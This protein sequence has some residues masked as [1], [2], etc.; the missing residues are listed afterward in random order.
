MFRFTG[1]VNVGYLK[2]YAYLEDHPMTCKWLITMVS[3]SPKQGC[4]HSKWAKW[5]ING[6]DPNYILTGMILQVD[7]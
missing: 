5:F 2:I 4:S 3:K 7:P 6:G 1:W